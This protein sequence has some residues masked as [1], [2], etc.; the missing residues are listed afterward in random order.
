MVSS[1]RSHGLRIVSGTSC[2]ARV[3][4]HIAAEEAVVPGSLDHML[5]HVGD[6]GQM[7]TSGEDTGRAPVGRTAEAAVVGDFG[8]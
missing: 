7:V 2:V 6:A 1:V 5:V 3:G 4:A 8:P